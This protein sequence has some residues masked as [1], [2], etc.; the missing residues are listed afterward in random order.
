[1]KCFGFLLALPIAV[2]MTTPQL[3]DTP[4]IPTQPAE[5]NASTLRRTIESTSPSPSNAAT[6]SEHRL[7]R[8]NLH[9]GPRPSLE[10]PCVD[11]DNEGTT[12]ASNHFTG[13]ISRSGAG[14]K[15]H[16]LAHKPWPPIYHPKYGHQT[17]PHRFRRPVHRH[18]PQQLHHPHFT[19]SL[20]SHSGIP[21]QIEVDCDETEPQPYYVGPTR[22]G[23]AKLHS[24]RK[25]SSQTPW[26]T[27][28]RQSIS[29]LA[30][31]IRQTWVNLMMI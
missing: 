16:S 31:R 29:F 11:D 17:W 4:G 10:A 19:P 24:Q 25:T 6:E 28:T 8:R 26:F 14:H 9:H 21:K 27:Y 7:A 3:L 23:L 5:N 18:R 30:N 12:R 22:A 1:M 15:Q 2:V 13:Q 20:I